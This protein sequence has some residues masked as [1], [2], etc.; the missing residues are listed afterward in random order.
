M[1]DIRQKYID[2]MEKLL[3]DVSFNAPEMPGQEIPITKDY[4]VE[5]L[6]ELIEDNMP[7]VV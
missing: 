6:K 3:E 4:V 5:H 1:N 7:W 2:D